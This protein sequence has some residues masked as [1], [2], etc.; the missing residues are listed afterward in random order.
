MIYQIKILLGDMFKRFKELFN[1]IFIYVIFEKQMLHLLRCCKKRI[2][3]YLLNN[4]PHV[5]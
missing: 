1:V 3:K 2:L 5:K 4:F